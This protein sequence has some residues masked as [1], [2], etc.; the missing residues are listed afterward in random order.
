MA[1]LWTNLVILMSLAVL[2]GVVF[3]FGREY[4]AAKE[5]HQILA[6]LKKISADE[7]PCAALE[8]VR[9]LPRPLELDLD[10]AV[11]SRRTGFAA[12]VVGEA[13]RQAQS[14][15]LSADK[16]GLVDRTLCEQ[17]KLT[18]E[19]G[20]SHPLLELL[21]FTREGG[22]PCDDPQGLD[23]VLRSLTSHRP[24]MLHA[25]MA[26]VVRLQCLPPWLSSRLA[27]EVLTAVREAPAVMDDVDVLRVA[28][29]LNS[30]AP[31][32]AAQFSCLL[33]G[34]A[35]P[36]LL[37]GAIGC[38]PY[39]KRQ[40][41]PRFRT[42]AS[43][44][45]T[46]SA[47]ELPVGSEVLLLSTEGERC[48]IR[49]SQGPPRALVVPCREL[50]TMSDVHLA[51]M[52]ESVAYGLARASLVAGM[53]FYDSATGKLQ[54]SRQEPDCKSW[55]GYSKDGEA[56]GMAQTVRLA[57]LAAQLGEDVPETPLRTFCRQAGAKYCYDVD[58]AQVVD[59]LDGEPIVF[60]SRPTPIFLAEGTPQRDTRNA[61][62]ADA[63]GKTVAVDA[64]MKVY[65][66]PKG[67]ALLIAIQPGGLSL[68]WRLGGG[69]PW[70]AQSLGVLEGG[71]APPSA[72][73]LV[74]MDLK[75]DGRPEILLQR[76][77]R[78][79]VLGEFKDVA[80]EVVLV[81]LDASGKRFEAINALTVHEY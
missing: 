26:Q 9:A 48:Q 22:D 56:L 62:L 18:R 14:A 46:S 75:N 3:Y 61:W 38:T 71:R 19:L 4:Y 67:G 8:K 30:W 81:G 54:P 70:K 2:A 17:I 63:F 29:F 41:L 57:D 43:I 32:R 37:A 59:H 55:Y 13:D 68:R 78:A 60:L 35:R 40:V 39:V 50:K 79:V 27:D 5:R 51:V 10:R 72:R 23:Q 66:L 69:E 7:G 47:P 1:R 12:E 49:P 11:E 76:V 25:L 31:V 58:W 45:A 44:A 16:E 53:I 34:D 33:E 20:E 28:K 77:K 36:S 24:L 65:A 80:D 6:D 52:V 21:R 42:T 73:L 64:T 74:V 15:L